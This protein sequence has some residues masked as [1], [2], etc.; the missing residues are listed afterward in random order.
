[1]VFP[2]GT[3]STDGSVGRFRGGI[4]MLAIEAGLPIVPV[5]VEGT[6]AVMLKGRLM[7]CP[8]HVRVRVLPPVSTAGHEPAQ[9]RAL[10]GVVE[11]QVRAGVEALRVQTT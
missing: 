9:A 4:V 8:G 3:R 5:S 10:A 2:E 11:R 7:T 6:R 1:V